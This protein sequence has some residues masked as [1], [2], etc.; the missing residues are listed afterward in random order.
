MPATWAEVTKQLGWGNVSPH[1]PRHAIY[2]GAFY[3]RRMQQIWSSRRSAEERQQLAEA[4]YNTGPGHV[5]QAQAACQ[6]AL[7]W[8]NIL[9]CLASITGADNARQTIDYVTR[10]ADWRRQILS[11][12]H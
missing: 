8:A 10:I 12:P 3:M 11:E 6:G 4:S 9:P 7:L 2:A 1:S 5:L